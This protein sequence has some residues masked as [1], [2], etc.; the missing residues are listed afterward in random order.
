M[1][2]YEEDGLFNEYVGG[3]EDYRSYKKQQRETAP[4]QSVTRRAESS[5]SS[6]KLNFNEQRELSKL[7]QQIE[8]LEQKIKVLQDEMTT[9][10]FYQQDTQKIS[11]FKQQL[12]EDETALASLY[13]RWEA[14]EGRKS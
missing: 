14:L 12:A 11:D 4:L 3:Y 13:G 9:A 7:P 6:V 8:V 10:S 2:V 1:L 5:K